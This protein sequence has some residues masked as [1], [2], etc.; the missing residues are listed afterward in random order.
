[1]TRFLLALAVLF[2]AP[3]ADAQTVSLDAPCV[4]RVDDPGPDVD[5][6]TLDRRGAH[7][8][9]TQRSSTFI[10]TYSGFTAEAEA[11]FQRA[12]DIWAAS[13]TSEV[14]I[15]VNAS[16]AALP[17]G[18]LGS[19]GPLSAY[20][21]RPA[22]PLPST[23]YPDALA[24]ALV[25]T[26][27]SGQNPDIQARFS[28]TFP[29]F[30]F[31]LD[32]DPPSNRFDFTTVVLHE[33]G[34]GLGFVGSARYD[35]GD[36]PNEC[37][38]TEGIGCW[39]FSGLPIVFDRFVEDGDG[40]ELLNTAIYPNP[41]QALGDLLIADDLFFDG[42]TLT[43]TQGG[44]I[45]PVYGPTPFRAGSSYSHFDEGTFVG[46]PD[47]LMTPFIN[48]GEAYDTP[49]VTTCALFSDLGWPLGDLCQFLVADEAG[50]AA[51]RPLR[52]ESANPGRGAARLAITLDAPGPV[53]A[54]VLDVLGRRVTTLYQ[55]DAVGELRLRTP[56]D[57]APGAYLVRVV[58]AA[59]VSTA[60][61]TRL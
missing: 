38:G 24:D 20:S 37:N 9:V 34:H 60:P 29:S 12:V 45:V 35:D 50:A 6:A 4:L 14:P 10:V 39:G 28:S 16:F 19:A 49:G 33:L 26:S 51:A 31:G 42:A 30:Y 32:S 18:V 17:S 8:V 44:V 59:G 27:Q 43:A 22:F 61:I 48:P 11:A 7:T 21:G 56:A 58:T 15:R 2:V 57:L 55:G 5:Q 23:L 1:M 3:A 36:A 47:A 13:L 53:R 46:S 25:G 41:S 52:V 40:D 54:D